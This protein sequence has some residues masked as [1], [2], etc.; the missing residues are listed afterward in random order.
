M[1]KSILIP[2]VVFGL[3]CLGGCSKSPSKG[4]SQFMGLNGTVKTLTESTYHLIEIDGVLTVGEMVK[5]GFEKYIFDTVGNVIQ[6]YDWVFTDN[7]RESILNKTIYQVDASGKVFEECNYNKNGAV[8]HTHTNYDAD[9]HVSEILV[10]DYSDGSTQITKCSTTPSDNGDVV[11]KLITKVDK[12]GNELWAT[13]HIVN[14]RDSLVISDEEYDEQGEKGFCQYFKYD[15]KGNI[16]YAKYTRKDELWMEHKGNKSTWYADDGSI[17]STAESKI[18]GNIQTITITDYILKE[19]SSQ[20][21][22]EWRYIPQVDTWLLVEEVEDEYDEGKIEKTTKTTYK[23]QY[24]N[25]GNWIKCVIF[26]NNK[27]S[28]IKYRDIEYYSQG[29]KVKIEDETIPNITRNKDGVPYIIYVDKNYKIKSVPAYAKNTSL[30]KLILNRKGEMTYKDKQELL[31][32]V[33]S[34]A[35]IPAINEFVEPLQKKDVS[36]CTSVSVDSDLAK[37]YYLYDERGFIAYNR[38]FYDDAKADLVDMEKKIMQTI[39]SID[40]QQ[41]RSFK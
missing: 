17:R 38:P 9:G 8:S 27:P 28:Q 18:K 14:Y 7:Y 19:I 39:Q 12:K 5:Y 23:Y 41:E 37:S 6:K 26:T 13:K 1:K 24:D 36:N 15:S 32:L 11:E 3:I 29:A 4:R 33:M 22:A 2:I 40:N 10:C 20:S 35:N 31:R 34:D 21:I 25:Q 30:Q 16:K